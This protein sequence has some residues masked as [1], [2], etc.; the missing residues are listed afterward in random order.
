MTA[1]RDHTIYQF[2]PFQNFLSTLAA[3]L[4][5]IPLSVAISIAIVRSQTP[6]PVQAAALPAMQMAPVSSPTPAP[7]AMPSCTTPPQE[8]THV[9]SQGAVLGAS[10]T[11]TPA[12]QPYKPVT[13]KVVNTTHI[14]TIDNSVHKITDN[15][16]HLT[17][18]VLI[19]DSFNK[20]S[21]NTSEQTNV[22][23]VNVD[24]DITKKTTNINS[25]NTLIIK[26]SGNS[27]TLPKHHDQ[28]ATEETPLIQQTPNDPN[29]S[30]S[31]TSAKQPEGAPN[32]A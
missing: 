27:V 17:K 2:N 1:S 15:S 10:T 14:T 5:G 11:K 7:A 19:K 16:T 31:E 21:Y 30:V 20:D 32:E 29:S 25:G 13:H 24:I 23:I 6:A 3:M 8:E 12:P 4:I 22:N 9:P 18:N 26:D 28:V